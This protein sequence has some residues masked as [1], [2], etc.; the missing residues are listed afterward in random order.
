MK[1]RDYQLK[2]VGEVYSAIREG[3]KAVVVAS[4]TGSGKTV[5]M[6]KIAADA[7]TKGKKVLIIVDDSPLINQTID[8]LEKFG[9]VPGV[10]KANWREN[11]AAMC[12]VA[13][14]DSLI[15][16]EYPAADVVIIDECHLSYAHKYDG[17][18]S[19]YRGKIFI[20]FSATPERTNKKENL[21]E[22][23]DHLV[24]SLTIAEAIGIN[25]NVPPVVYSI[26]R[27]SL[28]LKKVKTTAGDYNKAEI[29]LKMTDPN[30]IRLAVETWKKQGED[31]PTIAF[32]VNVEHSKLLCQAF[33]DAGISAARLDGQTSDTDRDKL[34]ADLRNGKIKVLVSIN[35]L[36]IGFDE[37]CVSCILCCRPTKSRIMWIQIV[38]RGLRLF[39]GKEDCIVLDQAENTYSLL[40]PIEYTP[41]DLNQPPPPP[42]EAPVKECPSCEAVVPN[43]ERVCPHCEYVFP[44][45]EKETSHGELEI[46]AAI[47]KDP[48]LRKQRI[49][50]T[51]WLTEAFAAGYNPDYASVKFFKKYNFYPNTLI[52]RQA[53]LGHKPSPSDVEK[54]T[55]YLEY[56]ARKRGKPASWISKHLTYELGKVYNLAT[57]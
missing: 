49:E 34:Y 16:R 18:F 45:K 28:G 56:Q 50:Y 48:Q 12:Q 23:W 32:T 20:G 38:G 54:F 41:P 14:I 51:Q 2:T 30:I 17:V 24:R 43:F 25:A 46:V 15:R 33:L 4:C 13:S 11:R 7:L 37:P 10:I 55:K 3:K 36:T 57:T 21:A 47:I 9:V 42:G 8:K 1:L 27:N 26:K 19:I 29:G 40:H 6:A 52:R 22:R 5:V 35:V 53:L 44:V 39:D 31:R